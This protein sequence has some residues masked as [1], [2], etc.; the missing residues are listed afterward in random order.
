MHAMNL[1]NLLMAHSPA[2]R[3]VLAKWCYLSSLLLPKQEYR[4]ATTTRWFQCRD[5]WLHHRSQCDR[6]SKACLGH[7]GT[8]LLDNGMEPGQHEQ[9]LGLQR[10]GLGEPAG[11]PSIVCALQVALHPRRSLKAHLKHLSVS[12]K[13]GVCNAHGAEALDNSL[14]MKELKCR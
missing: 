12:Y 10:R 11:A 5:A 2:L 1:Y 3:M 4:Q 14:H 13:V 9:Q 8:A 7:I 6:S